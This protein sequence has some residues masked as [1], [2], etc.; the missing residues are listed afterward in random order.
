MEAIEAIEAPITE[1]KR[2]SRWLKLILFVLGISAL[3]AGQGLVSATHWIR[4]V[5][6]EF[7]ALT[8]AGCKLVPTCDLG[9]HYPP[10][11][12]LALVI[13]LVALGLLGLA[14]RRSAL[15]VT[16][17]AGGSTSFPAIKPG[18]GRIL[19]W[20]FAL[21]AVATTVLNVNTALTAENHYPEPLGWL[22]AILFGGSAFYCWDRAHQ[23]A[24]ALS[25][26][27]ILGLLAYGVLLCSLGLLYSLPM[28][29]LVVQRVIF[30]LVV[31]LI[32]LVAWRMKLIS[33]TAAVWVIIAVVG[34]AVYTY[35]INSWRYAWIGDEYS[36]FNEAST[37]VSGNG[38]FLLDSRGV[39]DLNPVFSTFIQAG[40]M[41]LFGRNIY[42]WRFS[43]IL[44]VFLSAP[45]IYMLVR[46]LK[47][48][49]TGLLAVVVF[50]SAH[51]LLALTHVGYNNLQALPGFAAMLAFAVLALKRQSR[52]AMFLCGVAAAFT[53]YVYGIAIPLMPLPLLLLGIWTLWP[54]REGLL[55]R[56]VGAGLLT[57]VF[58]TGLLLTALPRA[59]NLVWLNDLAAKTVSDSEMKDLTNPLFQQVIPNAIY[60]LGASLSFDQNSHYLSGAHS[61]P[62]TS[63]LILAG[64]AGLIAV[65]M[66]RRVA[67][68][69]LL[70]F[71]LTTFIVGGLVPYPYPSNTRTFLEVPFYAI[72]AALGAAYLGEALSE[73]GLRF[74]PLLAGITFAATAL[75]VLALNGYQFFHLSELDNPRTPPAMVVREL[76]LSPPNTTFYYAAEVA[77]DQNLVM[78]LHIYNFDMTYWKP[79]L[80]DDPIQAL[81]DVRHSAIPPYRVLLMIGGKDWQ[82]WYDAARTI[83]S[84]RHIE[85]DID[86]SGVPSIHVVDVPAN[87]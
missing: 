27:E 44:M 75:A 15:R 36:F 49:G 37:F 33:S 71:L 7:E 14:V 73:I 20:G 64:I 48:A 45:A 58:M 38:R 51:H 2:R 46:Q 79:I 43:E 21:A 34:L 78:L 42:G 19:F 59:F 83:W 18:R 23:R 29:Q 76:E 67:I 65:A 22:V 35:N 52:L 11:F 55:H 41:E 54:S 77:D 68:W 26:A 5:P 72:F 85:S 3:I 40:S 84:D 28:L 4:P 56:L 87:S 9:G 30:A 31:A 13:L 60:V 47:G 16:R 50:V 17:D 86:E 24:A 1:V 10:Y 74:S 63:A 66:R 32:M 53:F 82:A 6:D 61:D 57:L 8:S 81:R 80:G 69:L 25:R 70:S 62:L 39:Y 12:G